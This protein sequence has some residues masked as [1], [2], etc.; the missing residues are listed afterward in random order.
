VFSYCTLITIYEFI[1]YVAFSHLYFRRQKVSLQAH[2]VRKTGAENRRQKME[3][4]YG[5]G[6]WV[7]V[8]GPPHIVHAMQ[9][10][11]DDLEW[12]VNLEMTSRGSL[13]VKKIIHVTWTFCYPERGSTD[14]ETAERQTAGTT[15]PLHCPN[16]SPS[17]SMR[18]SSLFRILCLITPRDL[19]LV[20][21][22]RPLSRVLWNFLWTTLQL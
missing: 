10:H 22:I 18:Y 15:L 21:P 11:C 20:T 3:S 8:Y 9:G 14:R 7:M 13:V 5:A 17:E 12:L 2:M 1:I 19:D 6:F 4:I 16:H